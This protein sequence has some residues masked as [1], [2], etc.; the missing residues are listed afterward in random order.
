MK[1]FSQKDLKGSVTYVKALIV[2]I[3]IYIYI[4]ENKPLNVKN[5]LILW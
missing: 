1:P 3:N 4:Y 5:E 2:K